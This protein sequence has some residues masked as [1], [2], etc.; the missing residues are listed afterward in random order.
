MAESPINRDNPGKSPSVVR[1]PIWLGAALSQILGAFAGFAAY[2][3]W[4]QY[5]GA[6]AEIGVVAL[7]SGVAAAAFGHRLFRLPRWWL[8]INFAFP[9]GLHVG[10]GGEWPGWIFGVLFV[11]TLLVFWNVIRDRVPLYLSNDAASDTVAKLLNE[12]RTDPDPDISRNSR[13]AAPIGRFCDL[14]SGTGGLAIRV[15]A[16]CPHWQVVGYESAPILVLLSILRASFRGR[17]T[18]TFVRRNFWKQDLS[19][20]DAVYAFLSP[21]PMT[22]LFNKVNAEMK[23]GSIFISNSFD[24]PDEQPDEVIEL[25]DGRRTRLLVWRL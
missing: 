9:L 6:G 10:V 14:G 1:L 23:A 15:A 22:K 16:Q 8:P 24:V 13:S 4:V 17:N 5:S 25:P 20:F 19:K 11:A 12:L 21:E 2:V 3:G 18:M 7:V